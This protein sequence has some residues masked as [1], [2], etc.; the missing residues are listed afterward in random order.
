MN[1]TALFN[2][3]SAVQAGKFDAGAA[4]V[5]VEDRQK[6]ELDKANTLSLSDRA[7]ESGL[8]DTNNTPDDIADGTKKEKGKK[9]FERL[10]HSQLLLQQAQRAAADIALWLQQTQAERETASNDYNQYKDEYD[11]VHAMN[12]AVKTLESG[13]VL[14][15]NRDG[16]LKNEVLQG[17]LQAYLTEKGH[18]PELL[19]D[20]AYILAYCRNELPSHRPEAQLKALV[21]VQGEIVGEYDKQI[22]QGEDAQE[23][24]NNPDQH[25]QKEVEEAIELSKKFAAKHHKNP[26]IE[27]QEINKQKILEGKY[28]QPEE[29]IVHNGQDKA[30]PVP[31]PGGD[32]IAQN[33]ND[34]DT[35]PS[36]APLAI[37]PPGS[38][39]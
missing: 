19:Q 26:E 7:L 16:S 38:S 20:D 29:K 23:V 34:T 37:P 17:K 13:E 27:K 31:P 14:E 25:S 22:K 2:E 24:V 9:S 35:Q 12:E 18:K 5:S 21:G 28:E 3:K 4:Y 15:R 30:T 32:M 11:F 6:A 8:R 36:I 39:M 33:T 1:Y 10:I